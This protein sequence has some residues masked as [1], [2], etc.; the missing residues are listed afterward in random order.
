MID[1][2]K[3]E[4]K[5]LLAIAIF[6]I[7][8][9]LFFFLKQGSLTADVGR[10]FYIPWQ[11][12]KGQVLYKDIF[13][14]YGPLSY[15][16][17]ALAYLLFGQKILTL[18]LLGVINSLISLFLIYFICREFIDKVFSLLIVAF[19]S[20]ACIFEVGLF[21]FNLPY[22]F[23][24]I[25]AFSSFLLAVLCL[26]KYVKEEKSIYAHLSCFFIGISLSCKYEY[27]LFPFLI[28]YVI[29]FLKPLKKVDIVKSISAFFIV[30]VVSYGALFVQGLSFLDVQKTAVYLK[31]MANTDSIKHL[32]NYYSGTYFNWNIFRNVI[33]EF[34][35]LAGVF[36]ILFSFDAVRKSA[37]TELMEKA[38]FAFFVLVT[39]VAVLFFNLY[40]GFGFFPVFLLL[41]TSMFFKTLKEHPAELILNISGLIGA[42]KTFFALNL[43]VYGVFTLPLAL[44]AVVVFFLTIFPLVFKSESVNLSIK[45]SIIFLLIAFTMYFAFVDFSALKE[46]PLKL[47]T[48]KGWI[49]GGKKTVATYNQLIDYIEKNTKA[50]DKV[51][52]LPEA[53]FINFLTERDSDNKYHSLIPLYIETFGEDNVIA[54]FKKT[55]P[56]YIIINNRNTS[57]YGHLYMCK[58]YAL[59]FC[60]FVKDNYSSV[61]IIKG[62]YEA[63]IYKRKDLK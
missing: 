55:K 7:F 20:Y 45:N 26:V 58:D 31:T 60:S 13:N 12:L 15:Q 2:I 4:Y 37:K 47:E 29:L 46:K 8:N 43:F 54:D 16:I 48:K 14:I 24:I 42:S 49:Y 21:N 52:M 56:E 6:F 19:I 11:M 39:F 40:T 57:D 41:L 50:T 30:P 59:D 53:P 10:E 23:A 33:R 3:K 25:Y 61:K 34:L 27:V 22:S 9:L 62:K 32:Y 36:F 63:V 51:I 5:F 17:N 35:Y 38:Y 44:I 1:C 18:Y 28:G